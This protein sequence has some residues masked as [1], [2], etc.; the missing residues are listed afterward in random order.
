MYMAALDATKA[1]DRVNHIKLFHRMYNIG[2]PIHVIKLV[3]NWYAK[4]V[5]VVRWENC[6]SAPFI[7]RSGVRQG[8][9]LSPIL[10]NLYVDPI[11]ELLQAIVIWDVTFMVP[12]LAASYML[13]TLYS[14]LH[15]LV[16][17]KMLDLCYT[18]SF[19]L[20]ILFNAKKSSLFTVGKKL[21]NV[22]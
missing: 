8:G 11:I 22:S 13:M 1:F 17:S 18:A 14:Y 10:F 5:S 16:T 7:M 21:F 12:I 3:M 15:L 20:D 19:E 6:Y 9:V 4:I 2:V